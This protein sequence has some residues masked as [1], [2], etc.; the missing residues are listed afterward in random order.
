MIRWLVDV[1]P[2]NKENRVENPDRRNFLKQ[3]GVVAF[4]LFFSPSFTGGEI[5]GEGGKIKKL[6]QR[7][8]KERRRL[9]DAK[10]KKILE[11]FN[12]PLLPVDY[13]E[14]RTAMSGELSDY[15][16]ENGY[17]LISLNEGKERL[18]EVR[19]R[20]LEA[21]LE[22]YQQLLKDPFKTNLDPTVDDFYRITKE[23]AELADLPVEVVR[24]IWWQEN[25]GRGTFPEFHGSQIL[26]HKDGPY[27]IYHP[28]YS[29]RVSNGWEYS[30]RLRKPVKPTTET[31]Q[32]FAVPINERWR[33]KDR[34]FNGVIPT[35]V[36]S[37]LVAADAELSVLA[38][39]LV[40]LDRLETVRDVSTQFS[41]LIKAKLETGNRDSIENRFLEYAIAYFI[42]H[43]D[44]AEFEKRHYECQQRWGKEVCQWE[45]RGNVNDVI[46]WFLNAARHQPWGSDFYQIRFDGKKFYCFPVEKILERYKGEYQGRLYAQITDILRSGGEIPKIEM[47][48]L[49]FVAFIDLLKDSLFWNR[50]QDLITSGLTVQE[51]NSLIAVLNFWKGIDLSREQII[52]SLSENGQIHVSYKGEVLPQLRKGW[53]VLLR[54]VFVN[55][56]LWDAR[57][58]ISILMSIIRYRESRRL[59]VNPYD[60]DVQM[61]VNIVS[62]LNRVFNA[63][64]EIQDKVKDLIQGRGEFNTITEFDINVRTIVENF[65]QTHPADYQMLLRT[66]RVL[67]VFQDMI[68]TAILQGEPSQSSLYSDLLQTSLAI[69]MLLLLSNERV[70]NFYRSIFSLIIGEEL[71]DQLFQRRFFN[72]KVIDFDELL[73]K[74]ESQLSGIK[75]HTSEGYEEKRALFSQ[76]SKVVVD[77]LIG[78]KVTVLSSASGFQRLFNGVYYLLSDLIVS[79]SV[80][81]YYPIQLAPEIKDEYRQWAGELIKYLLLLERVS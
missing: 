23:Y 7:I 8:Q 73:S 19:N 21:F 41:L 58:R 54:Y 75:L 64:P 31:V 27:A 43:R 38:G 66:W 30:L 1:K 5:A 25:L 2:S 61:I 79:D 60:L 17:R 34:K 76:I 80:N 33:V 71:V 62:T 29:V 37:S 49:N 3:A 77:F 46:G 42:Y 9:A 78:K 40:Y 4:T 6:L 48:F 35:P 57:G 15:F 24:A 14:Q 56:F 18:S 50:L 52:T 22:R 13:F 63:E 70:A 45:Y 39:L 16:K 10:E 68:V 11:L 32:V 81:D 44:P 67:G 55:N 36:P 74:I 28:K 51:A 59:G 65:R 69:H 72:Q 12:Q 47:E 26:S 53:R 20:L